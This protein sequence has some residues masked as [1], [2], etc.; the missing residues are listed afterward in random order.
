M[1]ILNVALLSTGL[2]PRYINTTITILDVIHRPVFYLNT[3]S[4]RLNS[5][6]V[7]RW[8]VLS[9]AQQIELVSVCLQILCALNFLTCRVCLCCHHV[10][11]YQASRDIL[12]ALYM[13]LWYFVR[14]PNWFISC[15]GSESKSHHIVILILNPGINKKYVLFEDLLLYI[16]SE[17]QTKC[18]LCQFSLTSSC[19]AMM[20]MVCVS[21]SGPTF[22][23]LFVKIGQM[24]LKLE[25]A[26]RRNRDS[27]IFYMF[28]YPP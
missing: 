4:R 9:L 5:V 10:L 6:S 21:S 28:I 14:Q 12:R 20:L 22:L 27:I 17:S 15:H 1:H 23:P 2:W 18:Q 25:G 26:T 13:H 24:T 8:N 19:T 16:I 7:F 3:T 11:K